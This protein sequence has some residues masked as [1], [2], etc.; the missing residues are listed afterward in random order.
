MLR[1][2]ETIRRTIL[3][4]ILTLIT[5]LGLYAF[6]EADDSGLTSWQWML[7]RSN[8]T[9]VYITLFCGV[10]IAY[11]VSRVAWTGR[12]GPL[13]LIV[14]SFAA[15]ALFWTI[16]HYI[17]DSS[18]YFAEAKH[19][20]LYGIGFFL[21]E[22]GSGIPA[23]TDLPAVPFFF[24]LIFKTVGES[25][26]AIQIFSTLLFSLTIVLTNHIGKQ[27]W[28]EQ[29]GLQAAALLLGMPY[30][31]SQLPLMLVD[32]PTMFLLT[33]SV[34]AL[35]KSLE[36][37]GVWPVLLTSVAV[38]LTFFSKYSS[39]PMLSVLFFAVM[40]YASTKPRFLS[41]DIVT[42]TLSVAIL[43]CL[44]IGT[45]L[46]LKYDIISEQVSL[47]RTFQGPGLH[48]WGESLVSM[49]FYQIHPFITIGAVYSLYAAA[50]K[51][52]IKYLMILWLPLLAFVFQIKRIRYLLPVLPMLALMASY[53]IQQIRDTDA[54]KF[55]VSCAVISSLVI[56]MSAYL[57]F[58][59]KRTSVNLMNAGA[60]IDT[61]QTDTVEVFTVPK[62]G[63]SMNQA[64]LVPLLDLYSK[65]RIV[66]NYVPG[67]FPPADEIAVSRY[68][69]TW[70]YK[71][72]RY[73]ASDPVDAGKDHA[74]AVLSRSE[75]EPLP[76]SV[77]MKIANCKSTK[78]FAI[79]DGIFPNKIAVRV[80]W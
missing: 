76:L 60:F 8:I 22:W 13:L 7:D 34:Y 15:G 2:F 45:A 73:Y 44:L 30:I 79:D 12:R 1:D 38:F 61:L 42:R 20:E 31:Y 48:R 35:L 14:L 58:L 69:F 27:L 19:L 67:N 11:L 17:P 77:Q 24:G 56:A 66:Y 23:W 43:S 29:T 63:E 78:N 49:F 33:L 26:L 72:P 37:G 32:I 21:R 41:R 5:F 47:L 50:R 55:I 10:A 75:M 39:W 65:K 70:E 68:R 53:G 51:K 28:D 54:R 80:F 9:R 57:P 4:A 18:R 6:R 36:H 71:N 40:A 59:Q 62:A 3:T 16:P 52:D 64:V 74:I 25:L 46:I